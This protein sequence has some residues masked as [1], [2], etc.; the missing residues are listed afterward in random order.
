LKRV[1]QRRIQNPLALAILE[2]KFGEGD[3]VQVARTDSNDLTFERA[4]QRKLASS[5]SSL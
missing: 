1:I 4:P 2:G 5:L 3:V